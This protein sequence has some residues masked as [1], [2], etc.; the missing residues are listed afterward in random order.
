[1]LAEALN[2]NGKTTEAH[3]ALN[4][5]IERSLPGE[6]VSGLSQTDLREAIWEERRRELSFEGHRIYD[7]F[8]TGTFLEKCEPFGAQ[9]HM[10]LFPIPISEWQKMDNNEIFWQ[11]QGW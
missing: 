9:P 10:I 5:V 1:M 4:E 7:L 3:D 8:R 11:N 6:G 2:E